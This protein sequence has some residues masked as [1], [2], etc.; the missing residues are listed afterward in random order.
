MIL[1]HNKP[2]DFVLAT[3]KAYSVRDFVELAFSFVD[4]KIEWSGSGLNEIGK[5]SKDGKTL[6]KIDSTY[7]R[8]AEV[9]YLRGDYSKA[10]KI[11]GWK[12]KISFKELVKEM[13]QKELISI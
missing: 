13:V 12:P 9:D 1:Q 4:I 6:V 10:K 3:S 5:N 7:F 2:D 11:L 8:P